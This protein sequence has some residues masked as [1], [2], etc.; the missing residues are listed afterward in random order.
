MFSQ[1]ITNILIIKDIYTN[2]KKI[3]SYIYTPAGD[4]GESTSLAKWS[5]LEL[6]AEEDDSPPP[7]QHTQGSFINIKL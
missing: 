2:V 5:S 7:N 6:L 3:F 4:I 1:I